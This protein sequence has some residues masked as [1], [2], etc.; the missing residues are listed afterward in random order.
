LAPVKA[1]IAPANTTATAR[2]LMDLP[3]VG[4][5][6]LARDLQEMMPRYT[7]FGN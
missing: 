6:A 2:V 4:H 1:A 7:R 5:V 3:L